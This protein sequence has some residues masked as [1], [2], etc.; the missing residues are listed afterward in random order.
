MLLFMS[1]FPTAIFAH[2]HFLAA[3]AAKNEQILWLLHLTALRSLGIDKP[4]T[5]PLPPNVERVDRNLFV[6]NA[7]KE[8]KRDKA[9]S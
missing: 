2:F 5:I 8:L 7:E 1:V 9:V 3:G 6:S 4:S